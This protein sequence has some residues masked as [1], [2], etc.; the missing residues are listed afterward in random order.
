M[1][2]IFIL[3]PLLIVIITGCRKEV[4][5]IPRKKYEGDTAKN[6]TMTIKEGTLT[7]KSATVIIEDLN[8]NNKKDVYGISFDLCEKL[9]MNGFIYLQKPIMLFG[10]LESIM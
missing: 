3:M 7:N 4:E 9:V 2:K 6:V 10:H 8:L 1:K 5:N